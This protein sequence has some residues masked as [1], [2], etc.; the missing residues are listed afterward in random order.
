[1]PNK[2]LSSINHDRVRHRPRRDL[3]KP[4]VLAF[5]AGELP[6]LTL[7]QQQAESNQAQPRVSSVDHPWEDYIAD[8]FHDH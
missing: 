6:L 2:N 1:M 7:D 5:R 8:W 4:A 3:G